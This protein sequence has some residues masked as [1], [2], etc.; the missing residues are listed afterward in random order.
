MRLVRETST[1]KVQKEKQT[2]SR[3]EGGWRPDGGG[4]AGGVDER[5]ANGEWSPVNGN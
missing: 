4:T 3:E 1:R 2:G 5:T